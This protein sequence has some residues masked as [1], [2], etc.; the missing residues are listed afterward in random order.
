MSLTRSSTYYFLVDIFAVNDSGDRHHVGGGRFVADTP[1][2]AVDQAKIAYWNN[3]RYVT[4]HDADA[5][6]ILA[7]TRYAGADIE[8]TPEQ[9]YRKIIS[10]M[11]AAIPF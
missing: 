10:D 1:E 5:V 3:S 8:R 11:D 6:V 9:D 4:S 2:Q 7:N